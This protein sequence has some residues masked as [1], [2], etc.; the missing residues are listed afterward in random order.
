MDLTQLGVTVAMTKHPRNTPH[1]SREKIFEQ[2]YSSQHH[3][4]IRH[5]LT[6]QHTIPPGTK[7]R[8]TKIVQDSSRPD[9]RNCWRQYCMLNV[10]RQFHRKKLFTLAQCISRDLDEEREMSAGV[11]IVFKKFFWQT[12]KFRFVEWLSIAYQNFYGNTGTYLQHNY[13]LIILSKAS[14]IKLQ[15]CF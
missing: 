1:L 13:K 15:H 11:A 9:Y 5:L 6:I 12:I 7:E 3:R 2:Y 10:M 14:W 8:E 4:N